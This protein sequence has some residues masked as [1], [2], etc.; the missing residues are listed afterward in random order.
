LDET[1]SLY[2]LGSTYSWVRTWPPFVVLLVPIRPLFWIQHHDVHHVCLYSDLDS[3]SV[4]QWFQILMIKV[5]SHNG[6]WL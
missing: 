2:R 3:H 5:L 4:W 1:T 6:P